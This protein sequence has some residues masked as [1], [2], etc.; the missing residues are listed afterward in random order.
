M[1]D[2]PAS[3][4]SPRRSYTCACAC[5]RVPTRVGVFTHHPLRSMLLR[6]G[7][8]VCANLAPKRRYLH[9]GQGSTHSSLRM[10]GTAVPPASSP[11]TSTS[12]PPLMQ[13]VCTLD[14]FAAPS[15]SSTSAFRVKDSPAPYA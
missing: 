12:G 8:S 9:F 2:L 11:S 5:A 1:A 15:G 4:L 3:V 7:E 14:V 13:S 6:K 10:I